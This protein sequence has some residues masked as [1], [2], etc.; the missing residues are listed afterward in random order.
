MYMLRREVEV[1]HVERRQITGI[2]SDE[3]DKEYWREKK[4]VSMK[5][6]SPQSQSS[7]ESSTSR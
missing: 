4:K 2:I 3:F 5:M 1:K 7:A 6:F